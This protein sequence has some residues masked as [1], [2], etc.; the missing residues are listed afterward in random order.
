MNK[1]ESRFMKKIVSLPAQYIP[2]VHKVVCMLIGF[3]VTVVAAT[4]WFT[5]WVQTAYGTGNVDSLNPLDR[6]QA[7]SALVDGQIQTWHVHEG[8]EIKAGDPIVTLID[9]DAHRVEKIQSQ[10]AATRQRHLANE[11]AVMNAQRNLERQMALQTQGLVAKKD[12]EA[13]QIK[14]QELKA[15]TASSSADIDTVSMT[16]SRQATL[17]KVAPKDGTIIRLMAGGESTYVKSGDIL[18]QFIPKDVK[19][20]VRVMVNGLDAPL[21]NP[22]AKARIQFEGWPVFQFSGWPGT[23]VGTFGGVV[24]YVEPIATA[25]GSFYV[26]IEPDPTEQAWPEHS[27]TRL[28]SRAK[29]WVLLNE[30]RLGYEMWRQLNNFPAEN[31]NKDTQQK[32][33]W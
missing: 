15:K 12:V 5:P 24:T 14:V 31:P 1:T 8:M 10:L 28:G 2:N 26:W 27:V 3:L 11:T 13:A 23:A 7:I 6:M 25:T 22:G 30:V 20:T 29:A 18:G 16:L 32:S 9:I 17:T 19:R 4:L 21:I 33:N